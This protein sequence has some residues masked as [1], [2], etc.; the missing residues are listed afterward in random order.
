VLEVHD[1]SYSSE[2]FIDSI[3]KWVIFL[4]LFQH[5]HD[6]FISTTFFPNIKHAIFYQISKLVRAEFSI[7]WYLFHE[8]MLIYH[9]IQ[10]EKNYMFQNAL[11]L[12]VANLWII[13]DGVIATTTLDIVKWMV[14]MRKNHWTR[15][16]N[17]CQV[18][19]HFGLPKPRDLLMTL[20]SKCGENWFTTFTNFPLHA[21]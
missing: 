17:E 11:I 12:A 21:L 18:M 5:T 10:K 20:I 9:T 15:A 3:F 8:Y 16:P 1:H 2:V 13:L 14:A 6:I 19:R 7:E 4:E